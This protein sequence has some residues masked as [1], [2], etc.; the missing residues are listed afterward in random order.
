MVKRPQF[1]WSTTGQGSPAGAATGATTH[2]SVASEG[3][4]APAVIAAT[5][6]KAP[7]ASLRMST[8]T[9]EQTAREVQSCHDS[10]AEQ[11]E[12]SLSTAVGRPAVQRLV[13]KRID[14][15]SGFCSWT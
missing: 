6:K 11:R 12:E 4:A 1:V 13:G 3:E 14:T 7:S 15:G 9:T 2:A 8:S 5:A 10:A